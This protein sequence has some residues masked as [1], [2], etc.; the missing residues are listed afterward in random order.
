MFL[1]SLWRLVSNDWLV[2]RT[3]SRLFA[4]SSVIALAT[5]PFSLGL[6]KIPQVPT[7]SWT[8]LFLAIAGVVGSLSIIF[9]W[10]GMWR[11]WTQC[12]AS[13]RAVRRIWFFV[14]LFG[15][16]Y[17]AVLYYLV[18]YLRRGSQREAVE[19][20]YTPSKG[21]VTTFLGY[22]LLVGWIGLI[23]IVALVFAFPKSVGPLLHPIADYFVLIPISLLFGTAVYGVMRLYRSGMDNA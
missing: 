16:W 18:R 2:G 7:L 19:H 20:P 11:Y 22:V 5:T 17:G 8:N 9:L 14:L 1:Q 3:A 15:L 6:T 23:A 4:A 10:T 13:S 21:R 12:D